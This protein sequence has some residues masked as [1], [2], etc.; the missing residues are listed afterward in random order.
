[1]RIGKGIGAAVLSA[2]LCT[3]ML[4]LP[5]TAFAENLNATDQIGMVRSNVPYLQV[6]IKS[7]DVHATEVQGK[8]GNAEMTLYSLERTDNQKTLTCVLLDNS[9][10]MTQD[11]ICPRGSFD[12]L[13]TGVQA[14][15]KQASADHQIGVYSIG[16][17]L[18]KCLGTAKDADSAKKVA[19][20][21]AALKGD[22]DATDLNT[23]LDQ[24]FDQV[25]ALS[26]QYQVLHFILLT[27]VSADYSNGIDLSEVQV[28][29]QYN[30]VPLYTV[31]NTR[32]VNSSTYKRLRTLSRVSGGEAQIY[33]YQKTPSFTPVLEQLYKHTLQSSVA[34]FVT[35]QAVDNRA[36][37]LA[38]TV[39]GT[40]YKETVLLDTAVKTQAP[41]QAE[42]R[43]SA[44]HQAFQICYRQDGLN[45]AVPVN[46]KALE[47]GA[48]QITSTGK[49]K[50]LAVK[51]AEKN[52]DGSYT[53]WMDKEIYSGTYDFTFPGITDLSQNA[54]AVQPIKGLE[55]QGKNPFLRVLPYLLVALA[56]LLVLLAFYLILLGLK[57]KKNVKTIKELF[58]TQEVQVVEER[59]HVRAAVPATMNITLHIQTAGA[60]LHTVQLAVQG[61]AFVGRSSICDVYIDDPKLSRQHF[62]LE[63]KDGVV[64]IAD[65]HSANGTFVNGARVKDKQKLQSGYTITAGLS[66]IKV[67]F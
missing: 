31:C 58:E 50:P 61:S 53:V 63:V 62:A 64:L 44:D 37:E 40:V 57:K 10:S 45:G 54:N 36:R 43:V 59:H 7:Q 52:A 23:A 67:E 30:K 51:K 8:L 11:N 34:C 6:E 19:A 4:F 39:G 25:S 13:K 2:L 3:A 27:D 9:A 17:G 5:T 29:Y 14:L 65:L 56:V 18:P 41:V 22:E 32:A 20:S 12:Q 26:D 35:D 55:L 28:K 46:A 24:L 66:T 15:L 42:I 47:N 48:Y 33:D 16:A 1:M 21:V 49:D 60:P 38:L